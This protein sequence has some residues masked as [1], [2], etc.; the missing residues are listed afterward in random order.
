MPKSSDQNTRKKIRAS[1]NQTWKRGFRSRGPSKSMKL[2]ANAVI[3]SAVLLSALA[4]SVNLFRIMVMQHDEYT[5]MANSRQF[6]TVT[7]SA[8]RGSIYDA[9]GAVL[10]QS[11]TVYKI[12]LDPGLFRKEMELVEDRNKELREAALKKQEAGGTEKAD[13]VEPAEI[14]KI[15]VEYLAETLELDQQK[16]RDAFDQDSNYVVLKK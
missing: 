6:N 10:A 5:E 16:I 14:K 12:F 11:A 1:R 3:L 7:L 2:R 4:L 13:V 8:A 9:N 15:V